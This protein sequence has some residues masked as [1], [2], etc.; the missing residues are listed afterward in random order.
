MKLKEGANKL[1]AVGKT[2][3]AEIVDEIF[4][5]YQTASWGKPAKLTLNE[6]SRKNDL[7]TIEAR[8]SDQDGVPC[9][10][11]A[12]LI[13]F[14]LTGDGKLLDNLGTSTGSRAV[15]LYNGRAQI[16]LRLTGMDAVASVSTDGIK[17][18]FLNVT[19]TK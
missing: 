18:A 15:Q 11:A 10:D 9:L 7:V 1:R 3:G 14:G 2:E 8:V 12:N 13:R 6:L 4:V 19:N 17:T 5:A 16:S